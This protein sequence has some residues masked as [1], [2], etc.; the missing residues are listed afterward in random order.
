L[1]LDFF[2]KLFE[3]I[4]RSGKN[5]FAFDSLLYDTFMESKKKWNSSSIMHFTSIEKRH[6]PVNQLGKL[7]RIAT[8]VLSVLGTRS[9]QGKF[10][11]QNLIKQELVA[12]KYHL[13]C[14]ST[15]P[16]GHLWGNRFVYPCG[17]N[18]DVHISMDESISAVNYI[19][20]NLDMQNPDMILVGGQSGTIPY[21]MSNMAYSTLMQIAFLFGVCSDAV[22][23]CVSAD[24]EISYI[25]RTIQ[26]IEAAIDTKVIAISV[27]PIYVEPFI[28]G[29]SKSINLSGSPKLDSINENIFKACRIPVFSNNQESVGTL[30]DLIIGYFSG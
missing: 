29:K 24:D 8:P 28:F 19:M 5:I 26:F 22:I 4:C 11:L 17:H 7:W 18:H 15:E 6:I 20:H 25:Q 23:L 1:G 10:T 14:L 12:R 9:M 13:E 30:V 27:F 16:T 3:S 2:D 21:D